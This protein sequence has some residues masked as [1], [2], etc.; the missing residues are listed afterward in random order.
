[1]ERIEL[2]GEGDLYVNVMSAEAIKIQKG[3]NARGC[4]KMEFDVTSEGFAKFEDLIEEFVSENFEAEGCRE[5]HEV[6]HTIV[7]IDWKGSYKRELEVLWKNVTER[8]EN[9]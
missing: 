3:F 1:M 4:G 8:K 2:S 7:P 9:I 6:G 5:C